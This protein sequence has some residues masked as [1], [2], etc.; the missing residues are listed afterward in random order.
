MAKNGHSKFFRAIFPKKTGINSEWPKMAFQIY[1]N[2][3]SAKRLE[4]MSEKIQNSHFLP[5]QIYT[6]L[7][8]KNCQKKCGT[9]I[10]GHSKFIPV[11]LGKIWNNHF[12][13]FQ[14]YTSL[15]RKNCQKK[16]GT[17]NF[18]HSEFFLTIF[19]YILLYKSVIVLKAMKFLHFWIFTVKF[20]QIHTYPFYT[21]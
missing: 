7:F 19:L 13:P 3:F 15:F 8:G 4:E 5:F 20:N 11:L 1:L 18:G 17:T 6:S 2:L 12:W 16:F 10:F 14:I 21:V 9:A